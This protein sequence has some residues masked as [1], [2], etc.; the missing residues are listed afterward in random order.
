MDAAICEQADPARAAVDATALSSR[1]AS[2][3][4]L[5][6]AHSEL[7]AEIESELRTSFC[8][9]DDV[10]EYPALAGH[11]DEHGFAAQLLELK[12]ELDR[13]R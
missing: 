13:R 10:D 7:A 2:A 12:L 5:D 3:R 11:V 8:A 6:W 9:D 4:R 1:A